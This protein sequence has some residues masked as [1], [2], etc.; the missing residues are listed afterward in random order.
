[1]IQYPLLFKVSSLATP[2]A[3]SAWTSVFYP[4]VGEPLLSLVTI[5]PAFEGPGGGYSPEDFY[6]LA[7]INCFVGTFKVI[8]EKSKLSFKDLKCEGVLTV[9]RDEKGIPWMSVFRLKGVLSGVADSDRAQRI[10]EKTSQS[11]MI[12]NSVKTE[13]IFEWV[14]ER[15]L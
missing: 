6:A 12:L 2:S 13:K 10:L 9:D 8:A 11:C 14:V 7:L 1:M 15:D 5:P 4:S 3:L